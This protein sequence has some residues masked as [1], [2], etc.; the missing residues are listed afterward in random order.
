MAHR[1]L[2]V[3]MALLV[4]SPMMAVA[5]Y[6]VDNA[7]GLA[8]NAALFGQR[9]AVPDG[10]NRDSRFNPYAPPQTG[11]GRYADPELLE[12]NLPPY[13]GR[14]ESRQRNRSVIELDPQNM[15]IIPDEGH[16]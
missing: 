14:R 7:T 2:L 8:P 16:R 10:V 12:E 6:G 5:Q 4:G 1:R 3:A 11:V 13:V 9:Y 15:R